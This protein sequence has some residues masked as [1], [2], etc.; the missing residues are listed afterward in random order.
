[1]LN[2]VPGR[3]QTVCEYADR[4]DLVTY[5]PRTKKMIKPPKKRK[6]ILIETRFAVF[7]GYIFVLYSLDFRSILKSEYS[8]RFLGDSERP[9]RVSS[10]DVGQIQDVEEAGFI[11]RNRGIVVG[12]GHIVRV[13]GDITLP[14]E[15]IGKDH[16]YLSAGVFRIKIPLANLA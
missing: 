8:I 13:L 4:F 1:M 15:S 7:P 10:F 16:F 9:S 3:E 14:V 11:S 6:P 5:F 12:E 2:V